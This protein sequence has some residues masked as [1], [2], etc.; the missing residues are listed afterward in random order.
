MIID[1][2]QYYNIIKK[3]NI[4]IIYNGPI[5]ADGVEGIGHTLRKRLEFDELPLVTSQ[6]IFSVFVEQMNNMVHYSA[7]KQQFS[8]E[9]TG[10]EF[11]IATGVFV[12]G[13]IDKKYF[14]QCGNKIKNDQTQMIKERIDYL[15]TLDKTELRKYYKEKIKAENDNPDSKGAGIGLIEIAKRSSSKME[16]S[17]V[18]MEDGYSF[19]TLYVTVG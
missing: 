7:D 5:W 2:L 15:N 3:H 1:M 13:A 4:N 10:E 6:S 9:S 16:Y 14:I 17:F 12:L 11:D 18:P 8:L 19:F